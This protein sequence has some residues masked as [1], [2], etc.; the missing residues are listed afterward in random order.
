MKKNKLNNMKKRTPRGKS[1]IFDYNYIEMFW[2]RFDKFFKSQ[3]IAMKD[4]S[5]SINASSGYL[6]QMKIKKG[7]LGVTTIY[8]ILEFYPALNPDW[9]ILGK[10]TMIR[11]V[12]PQNTEEFMNKI[13]LGQELKKKIALIDDIYREIKQLQATLGDTA[14]PKDTTSSKSKKLP[15]KKKKTK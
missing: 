7:V 14:L 1:N 12:L 8:K 13:G 10:G 3:N 5:T 9:L 11:G 4:L 15:A 2:Q 6:T